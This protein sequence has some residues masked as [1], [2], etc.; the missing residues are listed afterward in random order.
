MTPDASKWL[1]ASSYRAVPPLGGPPLASQQVAK[2]S[3]GL[4]HSWA[5][6][7]SPELVAGPHRL[8]LQ[9]NPST[10]QYL[11]FDGFERVSD[12]PNEDYWKL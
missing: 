4:T 8:R 10:G 7:T 1:L 6:Y 5:W 9:A 2:P 12:D 3:G 11:M